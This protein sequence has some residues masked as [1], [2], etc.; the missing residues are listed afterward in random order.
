MRAPGIEAPEIEVRDRRHF[1]AAANGLAAGCRD[2]LSYT[3]SF[4]YW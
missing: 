1:H 3:S 2:A 4:D